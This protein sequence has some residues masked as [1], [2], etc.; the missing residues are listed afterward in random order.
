MY[1][2]SSLKNSWVKFKESGNSA[3]DTVILELGNWL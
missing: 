3:V 2:C 1:A